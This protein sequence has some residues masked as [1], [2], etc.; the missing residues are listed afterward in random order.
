LGESEKTMMLVAPMA[1][2]VAAEQFMLC[3]IFDGLCP[4]FNLIILCHP[5]E[6]INLVTALLE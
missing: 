4:H 5:K 6:W 3:I 2:E 1:L